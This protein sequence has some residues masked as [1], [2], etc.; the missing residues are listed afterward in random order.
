M[1]N[2][3]TYENIP[4]AKW[5]VMIHGAGG[6]ME[7]WFKQIS[8]YSRHFNI[9]LV[10]LACHGDSNQ[11]E[12]FSES[13]DFDM[14]ARQVLEVVDHLGIEK[15]HYMGL[16]LG[17]I[18]AR[19]IAE[20]Y[21]S[22][23]SSMVLAGAVTR[24][25]PGVRLLIKFADRFKYLIPY[26]LM[27]KVLAKYIIP[28]DKYIKS[29]QFFLQTAKKLS[30]EHFSQWLKLGDKVGHLMKDF[31]R[32]EVVIPTLYLMGENDHLFLEQAQLDVAN[33]GENVS[34]IIIPNAGHVC[35]IDNKS[36]F[37]RVSIDF[38]SKIE[39]LR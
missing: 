33:S 37:N 31:I 25:T 19:V 15:A 39:F 23:V 3:K 11:K 13:F 32:R 28:Q 24:L 17:T 9:L 36:F 20:N 16:S 30:F 4:D 1:L 26:A 35:N 38:F 5:V 8:A 14:A 29:K 21:P 34:M 7:V 10:D 12:V 22:R 6:N 27:K 18:I 2:Y